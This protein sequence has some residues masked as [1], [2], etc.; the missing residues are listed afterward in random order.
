MKYIYLLFIFGTFNFLHS[1]T[2]IPML[3]MDNSWSVDLIS[4]PIGGGS[5]ST[6]TLQISL[7]GTETYN[8]V[9]YFIVSNE[10]GATGCLLREEDGIVYR[11]NVDTDEESIMYDFNLTVGDVFD[12]DEMAIFSSYCSFGSSNNYAQSRE[13]I[14]IDTQ[15]LANEN[16]KIIFF[17]NLEGLE[18][19]WI[20]GIG[21]INGFDPISATLDIFDETKLVCF[22]RNG[23]TTFF[24][25][26]SSCDNTNLGIENFKTKKSILYPNPVRDISV[27][28]V[29]PF[30]K[31]T[32]VKIYNSTGKMVLE[33]KIKKQ[34]ITLNAM[35]FT[36]GLYFYSIYQNNINIASDKFIVQ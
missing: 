12:F 29:A 28:Q 13:V 8:G 7:T 32:S 11:Y 6:T 18:E 17:E 4:E 27:L 15:F 9:D 24:N 1:Q 20:E 26:A 3:D 31:A 30:L 21:S 36:S 22:T 10:D 2:F 14:E 16:R 25:G 23:V 19:I 33:K 5:Q 35:D 34:S